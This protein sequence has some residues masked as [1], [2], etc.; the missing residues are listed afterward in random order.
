M[1]SLLTPIL[2][3]DAKLA[4]R[5]VAASWTPKAYYHSSLATRKIRSVPSANE[6]YLTEHLPASDLF[7]RRQQNKRKLPTPRKIKEP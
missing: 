1:K 2:F 7:G 6:K 4:N 5:P 3:V